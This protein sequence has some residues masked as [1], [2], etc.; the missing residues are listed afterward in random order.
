MNEGMVLILF[1]VF[2]FG[3]FVGYGI[4]C[5]GEEKPYIRDDM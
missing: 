2:C 1:L 4:S 5:L 3:A